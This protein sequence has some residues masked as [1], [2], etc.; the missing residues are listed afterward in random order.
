MKIVQ[1]A[2]NANVNFVLLCREG[3]GNLHE[4][5]KPAKRPIVKGN[6]V[7]RLNWGWVEFVRD[8]FGW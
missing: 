1:V 8:I 4:T 6:K 5:I 7:A 3:E 2:V